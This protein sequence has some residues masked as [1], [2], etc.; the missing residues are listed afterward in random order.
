MTVAFIRPAAALACGGPAD[1]DLGGVQP[2]LNALALGVV[3]HVLQGPPPHTRP[4]RDGEPRP[5]RSHAPHRP[6]GALAARGA[7]GAPDDL[8]GCWTRCQCRLVD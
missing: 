3:Q 5:A 6:R 2:Q 4:V 7:E 8:A 1:L